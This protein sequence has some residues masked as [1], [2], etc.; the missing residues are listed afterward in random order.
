VGISSTP[1]LPSL[2]H[3]RHLRH[4]LQSIPILP[5]P[6]QKFKTSTE[7]F[8]PS[9]LVQHACP[10]AP[11]SPTSCILPHTY[12]QPIRHHGSPTTSPAVPAILSPFQPPFQPTVPANRSSHHSSQPSEKPINHPAMPA[13][14]PSFLTS[15]ASHPAC[16]PAIQPST[17]HVFIVEDPQLS[18]LHCR[19]PR[20]SRTA[21]QVAEPAA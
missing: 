2:R 14:L 10:P 18:A 20:G 21:P 9:T 13:I 3:L 4:L 19:R 11:V 8:D 6:L 17:E 1:L 12:L 7:L 15:F 5:A 16:Q